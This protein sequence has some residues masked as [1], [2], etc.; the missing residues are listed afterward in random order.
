[1]SMYWFVAGEGKRG[2]WN[3]M[4]SFLCI[5]CDRVSACLPSF[6]SDGQN[7]YLSIEEVVELSGK[8]GE[9]RQ[10]IEVYHY[11]L[12]RTLAVSL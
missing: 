5:S 8:G 6:V 10:Q 7:I 1:M 4:V 11:C 9:G 12:S 2:L 3:S